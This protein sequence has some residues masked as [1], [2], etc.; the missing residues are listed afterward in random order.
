MVKTEPFAM[1]NANKKRNYF[2]LLFYNDPQIGTNKAFF[3]VAMMK[4][5]HDISKL[6]LLFF[7]FRLSDLRS[8]EI[9]PL[10]DF[11]HGTFIII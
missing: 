11:I 2:F 9:P 5:Q 3:F 7:N 4:A 1:K 10:L 8:K 6:T